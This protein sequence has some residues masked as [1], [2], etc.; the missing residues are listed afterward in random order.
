MF[1]K[2]LLKKHMKAHG[3]LNKDLAVYLGMS[4]PNFSTI[5]N[6]RQ[7]F[8]VKH[9]RMIA[10]RYHLDPQQVWFIFIFPEEYV[11]DLNA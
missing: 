9:I 8:N 5:W 11:S 3:D 7:Q 4:V 1:N 10:E 2:E 6:G